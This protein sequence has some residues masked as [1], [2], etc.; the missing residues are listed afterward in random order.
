MDEAR[1]LIRPLKA[2]F[3]G[4]AVYNPDN[5]TSLRCGSDSKRRRAHSVQGHTS[6]PWLV[7]AGVT[8]SAAHHASAPRHE[9]T[10]EVALHALGLEGG[11]DLRHLGIARHPR[12]RPLQ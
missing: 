5:F 12:K 7:R 2:H 8:I 6:S 4:G 10:S 11:D 3:K 9:G 1:L